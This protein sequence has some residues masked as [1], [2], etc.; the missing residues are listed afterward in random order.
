MR[1]AG[2]A[3]QLVRQ[4]RDEMAADNVREENAGRIERGREGHAVRPATSARPQAV[5]RVRGR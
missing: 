2:V 3:R 5:R 1:R 4:G